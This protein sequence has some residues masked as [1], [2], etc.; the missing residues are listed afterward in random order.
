MTKDTFCYLEE[1]MITNPIFSNNSRN[2]QSDVWIQLLVA[3]ERFGTQGNGASVGRT[4]R[5]F[6][7]GNGTVFII[8]ILRNVQQLIFY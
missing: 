8:Y 4:A 7:I 6:G 2:K 5:R 3:L 1:Q